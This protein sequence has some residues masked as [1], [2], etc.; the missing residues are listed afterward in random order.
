MAACIIGYL[1]PA[2]A[3]HDEALE[4]SPYSMVQEQGTSRSNSLS[5]I[6]IFLLVQ[7]LRQN[8]ASTPFL[9]PSLQ[10]CY[11][12]A[13]WIQNSRCTVPT[14]HNHL[15]IPLE[16]LQPESDRSFTTDTVSANLGGQSLP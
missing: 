16:S 7:F 9:P 1:V 12:P 4:F 15:G 8:D 13:V 5:S 2:L 10:T 11:L 3:L 14:Q 6:S